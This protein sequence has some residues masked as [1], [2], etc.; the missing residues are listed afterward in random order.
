MD[1][2]AHGGHLPTGKVPPCL[3]TDYTLNEIGTRNVYE[4][5]KKYVNQAVDGELEE[6]YGRKKLSPILGNNGFK[7]TVLKGK[8]KTVD[9]P[10]LAKERV[11]PTLNQV[12]Q[13]V[14]RYYEIDEETIWQQTRGKGARSPAR[15]VAMYLCQQ[16]ADMR[17]AEIA[18]A[19]GLASYASAGATIRQIKAKRA[20]NKRLDQSINYILLD[21]TP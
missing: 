4:R 3:T 6:F 19:F 11:L 9:I 13:A 14:C 7:T 10:E 15:S 16:A 8:Q 1:T 18:E 2:T 20:S 17:L 12:I 21:L 5:Y